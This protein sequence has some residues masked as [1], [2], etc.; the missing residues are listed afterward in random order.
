MRLLQPERR[1]LVRA[2]LALRG[3]PRRRAVPSR[4]AARD[5]LRRR[6]RRRVCIL[7][8]EIGL[9][10][11]AAFLY[12]HASASMHMLV[13]PK[14]LP[15]DAE[16]VHV[17][18]SPPDGDG[19]TSTRTILFNRSVEVEYLDGKT[20]HLVRKTME[21]NDAFCVQLLRHAFEPAC[22]AALDL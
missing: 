11:P 9:A 7:S 3:Q 20:K 21:G 16:S 4:R 8:P 13:A 10:L 19:V 2:L 18:I 6:L 12:D 17:R 1:L 5:Q 22:W 15:H 14:L